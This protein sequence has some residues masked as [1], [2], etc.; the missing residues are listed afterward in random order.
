MNKRKSFIS[1]EI[2]SEWKAALDRSMSDLKKIVDNS[3]LSSLG[4]G[5]GVV[6]IATQVIDDAKRNVESNAIE[7]I[8][9]M[10]AAFDETSGALKKLKD[11][12]DRVSQ[13]AA[14][15]VRSLKDVQRKTKEVSD[16]ADQLDRLNIA[17]A[18][19]QGHINSGIFDV[20]AKCAAA[21]T[22]ATGDQA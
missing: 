10:G 22:K 15:I 6:N 5:L 13:E 12:N 18:T 9:V 4:E 3:L 14:F 7:L 16:Y 19:L 20:S 2:S 8:D 1:E 17:M 21:I 11:S